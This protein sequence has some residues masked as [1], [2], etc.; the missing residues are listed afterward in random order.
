MTI[1]ILERAVERAKAGEAVAIVTVI[2]TSGS[3]PGKTGFRMIVTP[4]ETEG[5]VGGGALE[6][7]AIREARELLAARASARTV[8]IKVSDIDMQCGGEVSIFIEPCRPAAALWIF[9]GG[10]IAKALVPMA[11]GAGFSVTVVDHR[12]EFADKARFPQASRTLSAPYAEA[13]GSMPPG[14]F[15]VI[16]TH[17]HAH[18]AEVL[19][20]S[21]RIEPPLPYIGMIGSR[22][23]VAATLET[24]RAAGVTP[25]PNLYTPIGLDLGGGTP[26][27]IALS[28]ASEILGVLNG[29][30]GLPHCR[31]RKA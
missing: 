29:R 26:G 5:T 10:H 9:G 23:K 25:G 17:G 19:I 30:R 20:E 14:A 24:L 18:D 8:R 13:A 28:I 15:V 1:D 21:A 2:E 12:P 31:E 7:E 3:V 22:H 27:E 16:V 6:K 4:G 11:A